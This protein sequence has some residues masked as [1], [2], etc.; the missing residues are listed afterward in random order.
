MIKLKVLIVDDDELS[1]EMMETLLEFND[2]QAIKI[3]KPEE[4]IELL[5][6][7]KFDVIITDYMMPGMNGLAFLKIARDLSGDAKI[8]FTTAY[9]KNLFDD[10]MKAHGVDR[11]FNKPVNV[12]EILNYLEEVYWEKEKNKLV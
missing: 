1:L 10:N 8:V 3:T 6:R 5:K 7:E 2:F 11:M 12:E 9:M 4:A